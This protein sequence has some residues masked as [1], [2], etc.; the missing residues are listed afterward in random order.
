MALEKIAPDYKATRR[1][2]SR[3]E[4]YQKQA[5]V[6][7][8]TTHEQKE[9]E[10]LKQL[11]DKE[12]AE[13]LRRI[14]KEQEE[15]KEKKEQKEQEEQDN[16]ELQ[17]QASLKELAQKASGI[18]DDI[19]RL[20]RRQDYGAMKAKFDELE[21]TVT[22]LKTLKDEMA[23]QKDRQERERQR[24]KKL[25]EELERQKRLYEEEQAL[26]QTALKQRE[27]FLRQ[28]VQERQRQ[29]QLEARREA[30]RKQLEDGLEAMYQE[31]LRLYKRGDYTAAADKFK[32]VRDIIPGYKRSEQYMDEARQKSLTVNLQ[33]VSK[34]LDLFDSK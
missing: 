4:E 7:A 8:F 17:Q 1:Y 23:K 2:L 19:I 33:V 31:A 21:N 20:S 22:A 14:Q 12:N 3:I 15:Q 11:Q 29:D 5:G 13:Q 28:Q 34:A 32:D 25:T 30:I 26:H 18:N 27:E 6:E 10:H 9:A 24:Q 16:I